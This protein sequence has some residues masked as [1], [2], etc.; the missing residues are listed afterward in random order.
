MIDSQE[1]TL[2][3]GV[4][5]VKLPE[6]ATSNAT[7]TGDKAEVKAETAETAAENLNEPAET[8]PKNE[9]EN[10]AAKVYSSKKEIL[11]RL[12]A[13][14]DSDENPVKAEIDHLKTAFYSFISQTVKHSKKHILKLVVTL[15]NIRFYLMRMRN[16]L[17]RR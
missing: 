8:Q 17:R 11:E 2:N 9:I 5:E 15:R 3:Q 1:K 6:E 16:P 12:K 7:S 4:E 14:V 13:I 10:L